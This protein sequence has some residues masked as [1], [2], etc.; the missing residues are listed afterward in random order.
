VYVPAAISLTVTGELAPVP[1][2]P[3]ELVTVYEVIGNLLNDGAVNVTDT[4]PPDPP[5]ADP[6]VGALA[7]PLVAPAFDPIIGIG[8]FYPAI[9]LA[10]T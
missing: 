8:L 10:S 4:T 7:G 9:V 1:V 6:I 3:E 2:R 5:E